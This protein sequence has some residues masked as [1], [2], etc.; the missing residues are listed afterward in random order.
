[1][2]G[3]DGTA[4]TKMLPTGSYWLKEIA[5]PTGYLLSNETYGPYEIKAQEITEAN[6]TI[7]NKPSQSIKII[8]TDST[9]SGTISEQ[10]M[11]K[12]V[13]S[14]YETKE[15]AISNKN[16]IQTVKGEDGELVFT[17]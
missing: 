1:M 14:I 17:N 7:T 12:A 4:Y 10:Y 15:D 13:F 9:T 8:K 2:T 5:S 16:P 3:D 6:T 11:K